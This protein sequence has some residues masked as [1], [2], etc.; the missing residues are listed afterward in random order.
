M[1]TPSPTEP[2]KNE[3]VSVPRGAKITEHAHYYLRMYIR[4]GV[5]MDGQNNRIFRSIPLSL[6]QKIKNSFRT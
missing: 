1:Y 5:R 6:Q 4:T 2:P 3:Q